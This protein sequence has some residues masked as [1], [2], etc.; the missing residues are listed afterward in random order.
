MYSIFVTINIKPGHTDEFI[1]ASH[2][3]AQGS[4][5]DEPGCFRFD[6]NQDAEIPSRFYLYE[7][8]RDEEAF[9]AHLETPHFKKWREIVKPYFDGD[10]EK[11]VMKTIFPSDAGWERQK[12]GLLN[13]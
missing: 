10:T 9:K 6:M 7:V 11:V 12:P 13:W 5:R 1:E 4:T 8:Y 2:G 3:D